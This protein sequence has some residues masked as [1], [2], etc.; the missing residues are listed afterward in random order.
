MKSTYYEEL[1]YEEKLVRFMRGVAHPVRMA[2]LVKLAKIDSCSDQLLN[3][4]YPVSQPVLKQ[5]L[6][7]LSREGLIKG[8]TRGQILYYCINWDVFWEFSDCFHMFFN[9]F[10]E[11]ANTQKCDLGRKL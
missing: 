4:D 8:S 1:P 10:P 7:G 6:V 2:I 9:N 11:K 3:I 5:H